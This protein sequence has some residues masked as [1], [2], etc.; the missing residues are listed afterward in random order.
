MKRLE[1]EK[2]RQD[3]INEKIRARRFRSR[4]MDVKGGGRRRTKK[5]SRNK[6][7]RKRRSTRH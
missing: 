5:H 6:T 2:L 7:H 1:Q 4:I 3:K